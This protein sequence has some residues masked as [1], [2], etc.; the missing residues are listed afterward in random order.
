MGRRRL[1]V[2]LVAALLAVAGIGADVG[3]AGADE[4]KPAAGPS[5]VAGART[6]ADEV[7]A[8]DVGFVG[9]GTTD[10]TFCQNDLIGGSADF[11]YQQLVL[12]AT[13]SSASC[14]NNPATWFPGV[15]EIDWYFDY[16]G[17]DIEDG[18]VGLF[19]DPTTGAFVARTFRAQP[20]GS[21]TRTFCDGTP[22]W[23]G[24][25]GYTATM[26]ASCFSSAP[27]RFYLSFVF[28][29]NPSGS[30]CACDIDFAP[31]LGYSGQINRREHNR[32]GD[33]AGAASADPGELDVFVRG[34]DG[35][36]YTRHFE[37]GSFG[38]FVALNGILRG[39]P[40]SVSPGPG[41]MRV[42]VRGQDDALHV[43]QNGPGGFGSFAPLGGILTSSPAAVSASPGTMD[44]FVAGSDRALY[45]NHFDGV[46]WSGYRSLGGIITATPA[47]TSPSPGVIVV[48]VRGFDNG[49][50]QLT[51]TSG[52]GNSG[53]SA[54][55]GIINAAPAATTQGDGSIDVFVRGQDLALYALHIVGAGSNGFQPLGGIIS[56]PPGATSAAPGTLDVFIRGQDEALWWN[57]FAGGQWSGW[58]SLGGSIT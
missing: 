42:F 43:A 48:F 25:T 27:F 50:Y 56:G 46:N 20:D 29:E 55:G 17:D 52:G 44:V 23:N 39:T 34:G 30:T 47:V 7:A 41:D 37:N 12:T 24:S 26:P 40:A 35:R 10:T 51:L 9:D 13:T 31:N 1:Y 15:S 53:W 11:N 33:G 2:G 32:N 38:P 6:G 28:D 18:A 21:F 58:I 4:G 5:I 45:T 49:L 8:A 57:H 54:R 16:N 19:V 36:P 3:T 22:S 14:P